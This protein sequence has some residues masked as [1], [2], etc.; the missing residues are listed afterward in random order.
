MFNKVKAILITFVLTN[1]CFGQNCTSWLGLPGQPSYYEVGDLNVTGN[2]ITVEAQINRTAPYIPGTLSEGDV[3]SKHDN[4]TDVNYLLRPNHA[5]ITTTNGPFSTPD[6]CDISLN[7]NYHVAMVYDGV[8]LKFYRNGFLMCFIPATGN[9]VQNSWKTRIGYYFNM[10]FNENFIGY[11]NEVRIWNVARTQAQIQAYMNTSLPT[12]ATQP[13]LLAY[14]IFNSL[15]NQQGNPAWNGFLGGFASDNQTN[16]NCT[17]IADNACCLPIQGTFTGNSICQGQNGLLNF[18]LTSAPAN[19]PYTLNYS[20]QINT[21]SQ[22]N[23]QDNIQFPVSI[24]PTVTTQYPLL[25]IMDAGNCSTDITGES[26][27]ITVF[28]PGHFAVTPDTSICVNSTVQLIVSGGLSYQWTPSANL[29][30]PNISNP[31]AKPTGTT[32]FYV[33]GKD[34]NNCNVQDSVKVSVLVA[35]VFKTPPDQSVCK[36]MSVV[37]DGYNGSKYLYVW[38]PA[39][40]LNDP[41][42]AA[43]TATPD[44]DIVYHVTI[45]DPVCVQYD[46]GF[47]VHVLVNPSP[48]IIAQKSNDIDCSNLSAQLSASGASTYQWLPVAGLNDPNIAT[49]VATL[50]ST[51]HFVVQGTSANGCYAYDSVTVI[52]TQTGQNAFSVPNAFTPNNDGVNDCFGVHNWGKVTLQDFSIYNRWGQ[53]VF[54]TKNP[55]VC[56]DGT[57]HGQKQDAGNYIY[58]IKA[59]SFCGNIVKKGTLI[60]IR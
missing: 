28:P 29:N 14:Y 18:H 24:N 52:V 59:T 13:G 37:L 44:Q 53:R 46:S 8:T 9:L 42:S 34:L 51:T 31:V 48:A 2:Q 55:S 12:P 35:P 21:Y 19:P 49:P 58:L 39:T 1:N 6:I 33:T 43:P 47:D 7:K 41:N 54:E 40:F 57:F 17:F 30:D 3:V 50:S 45:S 15:I 11:I 5:Y 56:W 10:A 25:K 4:V 38:S 36:G 27:T 60:L 16:S 26:A 22:A 32:L 23:V 20:D